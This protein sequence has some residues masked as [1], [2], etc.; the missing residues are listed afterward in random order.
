MSLEIKP[1]TLYYQWE[2]EDVKGVFFT[3]QWTSYRRQE[4]QQLEQY[5]QQFLDS[6]YTGYVDLPNVPHNTKPI[7]GD[8]EI[9]FKTLKQINKS[10]GFARNIRRVMKEI[11]WGNVCWYYSGKKCG[12]ETSTILEKGFE[13]YMAGGQ[14]TIERTL[15]KNKWEYVVDYVSMTQKNTKRGTTRQLSRTAKP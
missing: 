8:Y 2:W 12:N 11:H 4:N 10:T 15:G 9:D 13:E 14:E 7:V 5:Y 1:P 6:I 3:S